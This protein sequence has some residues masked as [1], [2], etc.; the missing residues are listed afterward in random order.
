[1]PAT[2]DRVFRKQGARAVDRRQKHGPECLHGED[3]RLAAPACQMPRLCR[4]RHQWLFDEHGIFG[5]N[6]DAPVR[7]GRSSATPRR[8]HRS[9][10]RLPKP[11]YRNESRSP[12][13][14]REKALAASTV[15]E[16]TATSSA[17]R[18]NGCHRQRWRRSCR[19]PALPHLTVDGDGRFLAIVFMAPILH[20][21]CQKR[22]NIGI[23]GSRPCRK[24]GTTYVRF[25][26]ALW[27][28]RPIKS[29]YR[30]FGQGLNTTCRVG[31]HP[32]KRPQGL[33]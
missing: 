19:S 18:A 27:N 23:P 30:R 15:R 25:G 7:N 9:P 13:K 33:M 8:R 31:Q 32:C 1:M 24:R 6:S 16:H 3:V 10:G 26:D 22:V 21:K 11:R 12:P 28:G 5:A 20:D 17:L 14:R 2:A 29:N 4:G